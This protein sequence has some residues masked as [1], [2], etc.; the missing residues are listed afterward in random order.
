MAKARITDV[1]PTPSVQPVLRADVE[2]RQR[3]DAAQHH[4]RQGRPDRQLR[5]VP[6]VD[7]LEPPAVLLLE[8]PIA[9]LFVTQVLDCHVLVSTPSLTLRVSRWIGRL[10][11]FN[12]P[13]LPISQAVE[14][15]G[16]KHADGPQMSGRKTRNAGITRPGPARPGMIADRSA[17]RIAPSDDSFPR[18]ARPASW[19]LRSRQVD[20]WP[21]NS[22]GHGTVPARRI[23]GTA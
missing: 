12:T 3:Q 11:P 15:R 22:S 16:L 8:R 6:A 23:H 20:G 1:M 9:N 10:S 5:H 2:V 13:T 14:A 18:H 19:H 17:A 4:A 7:V 21:V